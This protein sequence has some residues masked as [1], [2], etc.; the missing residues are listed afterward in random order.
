MQDGS[1]DIRDIQPEGMSKSD[2]IARGPASE[3][4]ATP[5]EA[6][7]A[8][9]SRD[10]AI[11]NHG[12]LYTHGGIPESV[13]FVAEFVE[14]HPDPN[15]Q[16]GTMVWSDPLFR[17]IDRV[18]PDRLENA[19]DRRLLF[20]PLEFWFDSPGSGTKPGTMGLLRKLRAI[21]FL[22]PDGVSYAIS[23]HQ[24]IGMP[25]RYSPPTADGGP[26]PVWVHVFGVDCGRM[27]STRFVQRPQ[28]TPAS[29]AWGVVRSAGNPEVS[30]IGR[31]LVGGASNPFDAVESAWPADTQLKPGQ[32][33]Q[34][35]KFVGARRWMR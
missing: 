20:C 1:L 18:R 11:F 15:C 10:F 34:A 22:H 5:S 9:L 17:G 21:S 13:D 7:L 14:R 27:G 23:T 31:A 28:P 29:P 25:D 12:C 2:T 32:M 33:E 6:D 3:I 19:W 4:I 16:V 24:M 35:D 26:P 30:G 8:S